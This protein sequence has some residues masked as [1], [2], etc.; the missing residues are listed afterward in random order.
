MSSSS[1]TLSNH[2][3]HES[4]SKPLL[5]VLISA[6]FTLI[7]IICALLTAPFYGF[8]YLTSHLVLQPIFKLDRD[9][10]DDEA[11]QYISSW[12]WRWSLATFALLILF[13]EL[14]GLFCLSYFLIPL[15]LA[16]RIVIGI[17]CIVCGLFA[18]WRGVTYTNKHLPSFSSPVFEYMA[19]SMSAQVDF[20][21]FLVML[22][23]APLVIRL[24]H[25]S[26]LSQARNRRQLRI[27]CT[28]HLPYAVLDW[29]LAPLFV[30][31]W[32]TWRAPALNPL[33]HS[34]TSRFQ[35]MRS[36]LAHAWSL[37]LRLHIVGQFFYTIFDIVSLVLLITFTL[38]SP[39]RWWCGMQD[40]YNLL[41]IRS[42]IEPRN[43]QS[44]VWNYLKIELLSS[45]S[46][47]F[48][49]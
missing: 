19:A 32:L 8:I 15:P 12:F 43:N 10:Q 9:F 41:M 6:F 22:M 5:L 25:F 1:S 45:F 37:A 24:P 27:H 7:S 47:D 38:I 44:L 3:S 20:L 11:H 31:T 18:F 40:L 23:S 14:A 34:S 48:H 46:A 49:F 35:S 2:D 36:P 29:I 26:L 21:V 30:F 42:E 39:Y 28:S 13:G 4:D 17:V 33:N 16:A